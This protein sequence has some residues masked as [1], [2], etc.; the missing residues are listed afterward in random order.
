MCIFPIPWRRRHQ[1]PALRNHDM[2]EKFSKQRNNLKCSVL[3]ED[4]LLH[5][6]G[7]AS[8]AAGNLAIPWPT[9]VD[10]D[11]RRLFLLTAMSV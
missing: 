7:Q 2:Q 9:A 4:T 3:T 8:I 5:P 1:E 6:V 11:A 10:A